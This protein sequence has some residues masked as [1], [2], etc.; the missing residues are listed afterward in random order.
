[1]ADIV[2]VPCRT[3]AHDH[4]QLAEALGWTVVQVD[5]AIQL[6]G[7]LLRYELKTPR[8]KGA[9][10]DELVARRE[11]LASALDEAALLSVGEMIAALG[12]QGAEWSQ[13]REHGIIPGPDCGLFWSRALASDLAARSEDL[14]AQIPP[15]PLGANNCTGMLRDLTGLDVTRDDFLDPANGGHVDCVDYYKDWPLFD[16]AARAA[17]RHH[18]GREGGRSQRGRRPGCLDGELGNHRGCRAVAGEGRP[19]LRAH[20]SRAGHQGGP[21]PA[22]S[23]RASVSSREPATRLTA[24]SDATWPASSGCP[25]GTVMAARHSP[26][27]ATAAAR[28]AMTFPRVTGRLRRPPPGQPS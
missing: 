12:M 1:V 15:Q 22:T 9:T 2:P 20:R 8:R 10:V 28:S 14:R 24:G 13:G 21:V 6:G 4:K 25:R 5:K 18:R 26:P 7:I 16:V 19:R 11:E 3:T 27:G 17:P 23:S